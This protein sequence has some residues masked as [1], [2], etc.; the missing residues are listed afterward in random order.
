MLREDGSMA[1][2]GEITGWADE[3]G[4]PVVDIAAWVRA[5]RA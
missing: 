5:H 1:R 3:H 2:L 4:I